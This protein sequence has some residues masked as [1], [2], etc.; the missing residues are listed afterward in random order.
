[1]PDPDDDRILEVAVR[2]R[3]AAVT[4]NARDFVGPEQ[5]GIRVTSPREVEAVVGGDQ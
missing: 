4:F 5:F 1:M 3:S 2:T